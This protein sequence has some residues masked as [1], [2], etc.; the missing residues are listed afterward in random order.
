VFIA[1]TNNSNVN[2]SHGSVR[3]LR[4]K[5]NDPAALDVRWRD[6]AAG[7]PTG[8]SNPDAGGVAPTTWSSTRPATSGW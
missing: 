4:E 6:Y 8:S 2:D 5:G 7:G 3:R 1:L